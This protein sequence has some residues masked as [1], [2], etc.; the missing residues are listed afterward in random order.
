LI[1]TT[2]NIIIG[3]YTTLNWDSS[4]RNKSNDPHAFVFSLTNRKKYT[5]NNQNS[6]IYCCSSYGPCFGGSGTGY[7][8][9]CIDSNFSSVSNS[10]DSY[11]KNEGIVN[12]YNNNNLINNPV[13]YLLTSRSSN[14]NDVEVYLVTTLE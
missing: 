2:D 3:G 1:K 13:Y 8:D 4:S 7:Y 6:V 14:I 11:G 9:I 10:F 5:C 12:N